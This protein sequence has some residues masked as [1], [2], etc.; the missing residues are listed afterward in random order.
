MLSYTA[1]KN[2][3]EIASKNTIEKRIKG[4]S[5]CTINYYP[6]NVS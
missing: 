1:I 2:G 3:F 5:E 4:I 6:S